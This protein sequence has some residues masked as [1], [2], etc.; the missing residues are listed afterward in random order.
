MKNT[1]LK[2]PVDTVITP[3]NEVS[4]R[5]Y[6]IYLNQG[7]P[8][9]Q[10]L[11]HWFQAEAE[12]LHF[13]LEPTEESEIFEADHNETDTAIICMQLLFHKRFQDYGS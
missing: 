3:Q 2:A 11:K 9:G 8:Q 13:Q 1:P 7:R 6:F 5:A 12:A 10:D 4:K